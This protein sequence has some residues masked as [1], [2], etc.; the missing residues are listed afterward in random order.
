MNSDDIRNTITKVMV[1]DEKAGAFQ[2][3]DEFNE[4]TFNL[5]LEAAEITVVALSVTPSDEEGNRVKWNRNQ[6]IIGGLMV[7]IHKLQ[8]GILD[9]ITKRRSEIAVILIRCL[10]ESAINLKYLA[11][12]HSD[13]TYDAFVEYSLREEKRLLIEVDKRM[14]KDAA[15]PNNLLD[16]LNQRMKKSI[17]SSFEVSGVAPEQVDAEK[18]GHWDNK[19][20]YKKAEEIGDERGY[21]SLISLP[22]HSVHG[23]WQDLLN[24]NLQVGDG[25]FQLNTAFHAPRP[26][27]IGISALL[28]LDAC[29]AF[30]DLLPKGPEVQTLRDM[31]DDLFARV[32]KVQRLHEQFLQSQSD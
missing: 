2:S 20:L 23:S 30:L 13:A 8:H 24:H 5:L 26:Q 11:A 6:A 10:S 32:Q 28:S 12:K 29:S 9:A 25:G 3:E 4:L 27:S 18:K 1:D 21:Q 14:A 22:S 16:G 15:G 19:T 17:L 31:I 7:R